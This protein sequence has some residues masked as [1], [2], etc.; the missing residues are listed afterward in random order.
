MPPI[1]LQ[2][3]IPPPSSGPNKRRRS[4]LGICSL[5]RVSFAP[6]A[7]SARPAPSSSSPNPPQLKFRF[8]PHAAVSVLLALTASA[9]N[10]IDNPNFEDGSSGWEL[11]VPAESTDK[12]ARFEIVHQNPR[13]GVSAVRLIAD[14]TARFSLTSASRISVR[15]GE[16]YRISAWYRAEPGAKIQ[17]GQPGLVLRVNLGKAPDSPEAP[18]HLHILPDGSVTRTLGLTAVGEALATTWTRVEAVVEVPFGAE[19]IIL[20][21]FAWGLQ[22][23]IQV[24]D[25]VVTPA[26][27]GVAATSIDEDETELPLDQLLVGELGQERSYRLTNPGF[28]EGLLGWDATNDGAMSSVVPIAAHRGSLGLRVVDTSPSA[29]SSIHSAYLPISSGKKYE[30]RFWARIAEGDGIGVYLRFYDAKRTLLTTAASGETR[31][32][33][34]RNTPAFR[35]FSHQAEAPAEAAFVRIWIHSFNSGQP[36]ADFDE[37]SLV[38]IAP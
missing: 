18:K 31:I 7:P 21:V 25:I 4:R 16:L 6:G 29:G 23:A 36:V 3:I 17:P 1:H 34:P 11:F 22:G 12:G 20:N 8:L 37:F 30:V 13:S 19:H 26:P 9:R 2:I 24:D 28:E 5:G 15:P 33:I 10:L 35:L 32:A 14:Q 27:P 38:E